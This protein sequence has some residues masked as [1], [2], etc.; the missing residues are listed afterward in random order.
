M[1]RLGVRATLEPEVGEDR[2]RAQRQTLFPVG[3]QLLS[4]AL[5]PYGRNPDQCNGRKVLHKLDTRE[6]THR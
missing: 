6:I 3:V 1:Q 5:A 2:G 4:V